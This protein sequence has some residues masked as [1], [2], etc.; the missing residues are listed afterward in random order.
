MATKYLED[1]KG[2]LDKNKNTLNSN[3]LSPEKKI[4]RKYDGVLR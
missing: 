3:F 1:N 2:I 4:L